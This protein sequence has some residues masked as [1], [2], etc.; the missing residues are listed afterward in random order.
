MKKTLLFIIT[1]GAFLAVNAQ[2]NINN[3]QFPQVKT[4]ECEDGKMLHH[5]LSLNT[6]KEMTTYQIGNNPEG[7]YPGDMIY[8]ADGSKIFIANSYSNNVTILNAASGA[9]LDNIEVGS[10]PITLALTDEYAVVPCSMSSDVY[11][12]DL[13]DNSIAATINVNG[14]PVSVVINGS[15][16]YVGC[17]IGE[18]SSNLNDECAIIDLT[19]LSLENTIIDFPVKITSWSYTFN[20]GR[21]FYSYNNF[22]VSDD[23]NYIIVGN[24][25]DKINFYNTTTGAIDYQLDA[26]DVKRVS[27]SGDGSTVIAFSVDNLYQVDIATHS[28]TETVNLGSSSL[29]FKC[30]GIANQDGTKA[31]VSLSA[32]NSAFVNF[33]TSS[34]NTFTQTQTPFWIVASADRS[35]VIGGQKNFTVFDFETETILGQ[36]TSFGALVGNV[37]PDCTQAI[38]ASFLWYEGPFFYDLSD[39]NNI[40]IYDYKPTGEAPEGDAPMRVKITPDGKTALIINELSHNVFIFDIPTST[41][42]GNFELDGAPM[43]IEFT[44]DGNYAVITTVYLEAEIVIFDMNTE[45]I[46][47]EINTG[48]SNRYIEILPDNSKAYVRTGEDGIWVIN[49]DGANSSLETIIACGNSTY[50]SSGYGIFTDHVVT[51]DGNYLFV[52]ASYDDEIQIIDTEIDEIVAELPTGSSPYFIAFNDA[53]NRA[54]VSDKADDKYT[55][56]DIDGENSSIIGDFPI[57]FNTEVAFRCAYNSMNDEFGITVFGNY[58]YNTGAQLITA[59]ANTGEEISTIDF[60]DEAGNAMQVE[61]DI[62]GNSMVLTEFSFIHGEEQYDFPVKVKYMAYSPQENVALVISPVDDNLYVIDMTTTGMETYSIANNKFILH[63]NTPNP[64]TAF[65]SVNYELKENAAVKLAVFDNTGKLIQ[66]FNK[67]SQK[68]GKYSFELNVSEFNSG[69]YYYTLSVDN[70]SQTKKMIVK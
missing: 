61:Y 27:K 11:I 63:Q 8:S 29:F 48:V 70:Q 41:F 66:Q 69:V 40:I 28:L 62:E 17:D 47:K 42:T 59:D 60:P 24:W 65:T 56:I 68:K 51:P 54:I 20:H 10:Y 45:T 38:G 2:E 25:I 14:E 58:Y 34:I 36:N 6:N 67:G 18:S 23:G 1:L 37:S 15:K 7:D 19:T 5:Y 52:C 16:A 26:T 57:D 33:T 35:K 30:L 9:A 39:L 12:I 31:F 22:E 32:N 46:V 43:D 64:A 21:N 4:V 55:L 53:S 49:L 50:S 13:S 44:S 3:E